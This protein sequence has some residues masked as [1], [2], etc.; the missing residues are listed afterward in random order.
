MT[1]KQESLETFDDG[2]GVDKPPQEPSEDKTPSPENSTSTYG[3]D[4][5]LPP[6]TL[7]NWGRWQLSPITYDD[8]TVTF[9]KTRNNSFVKPIDNHAIKADKI[10][11]APNNDEVAAARLN[12][13]HKPLRV[14]RDSIPTTYSAFSEE[15]GQHAFDPII[16]GQSISFGGYHCLDETILEDAYRIT[17]GTGR[18][19]PSKTRVTPLSPFS[20]LIEDK[21]RQNAY[22]RTPESYSLHNSSVETNSYS[23]TT[24]EIRNISVPDDNPQV[25]QL[26][27]E[28]FE[29]LFRC[30]DIRITEHIKSDSTKHRFQCDDGQ[31]YDIKWNSL[32]CLL[33]SEPLYNM[34]EL[35][36]DFTFNEKHK[37]VSATINKSDYGYTYGEWMSEHI[38]SEKIIAASLSFIDKQRRIANPV[39]S[40]SIRARYTTVSFKDINKRTSTEEVRQINLSQSTDKKIVD[41]D[42][43]DVSY[44]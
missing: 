12:N 33:R 37:S 16:L 30:Y 18:I 2:E 9:P 24:T 29:H 41:V 43:A 13:D 10:A 31:L 25:A 19:D 39:S 20:I 23:P 7:P 26:L 3:P 44:G 21:T 27:D 35:T 40:R 42:L 17:Q 8:I 22:I 28:L 11:F 32:K 1:S 6:E 5:R 14:L 36:G 15:K 4:D 38:K 34:D